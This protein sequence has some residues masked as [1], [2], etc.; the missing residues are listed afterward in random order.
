MSL[1][2][3]VGLT[4][5]I[6]ALEAAVA[7]PLSNLDPIEQ[8]WEDPDGNEVMPPE[9]VPLWKYVEVER[10]GPDTDLRAALEADLHAGDATWHK[11]HEICDGKEW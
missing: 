10:G 8:H 1:W 6:E 5:R 2:D 7:R 9:T 4:K 3:F 11:T